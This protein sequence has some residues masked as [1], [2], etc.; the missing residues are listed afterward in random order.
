MDVFMHIF[1]SYRV[2][3]MDLIMRFNSV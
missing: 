3:I 2:H 1:L